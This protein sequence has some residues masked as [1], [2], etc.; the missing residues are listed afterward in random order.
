MFKKKGF[1]NGKQRQQNVLHWPT[2]GRVEVEKNKK[3][4]ER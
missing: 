4:R 2:T 3:E 1:L